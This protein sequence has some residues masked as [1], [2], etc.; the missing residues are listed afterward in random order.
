MS[1]NAEGTTPH[2]LHCDRL[3]GEDHCYQSLEQPK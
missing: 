3:A 1:E 2:F